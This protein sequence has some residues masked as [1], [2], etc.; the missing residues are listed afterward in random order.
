MKVIMTPSHHFPNCNACLGLWLVPECMAREWRPLPAFLH[1]T[2]SDQSPQRWP[3]P[4]S[5][6]C[7]KSH[8]PG[9]TSLILSDKP[10]SLFTPCPMGLNSLGYETTNPETLVQSGFGIFKLS[11]PTH[12]WKAMHS[13]N[14]LTS[15]WTVNRRVFVLFS[16]CPEY[17]SEIPATGKLS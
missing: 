6:S 4:P 1:C 16:K 17:T 11:L 12:R 9:G 2:Q 8:K 13:Q 3:E 14:P 10:I 7:L 15:T 5:R